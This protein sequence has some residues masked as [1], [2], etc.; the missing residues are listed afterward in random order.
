VR[1]PESRW[2]ATIPRGRLDPKASAGDR[3]ASLGA[4]T[5]CRAPAEGRDLDPNREL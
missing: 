1:F 5:G 2:H 4:R 3:A